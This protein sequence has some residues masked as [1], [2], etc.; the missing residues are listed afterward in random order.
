MES[1]PVQL[2]G[3]VTCLEVSPKAVA[4]AG[5][6]LR[7]ADVELIAGDLFAQPWSGE[8]GRFE[9]DVAAQTDSVADVER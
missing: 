4:R 1:F 9:A 3:R 8:R 6:R 5:E 7:S 2:G